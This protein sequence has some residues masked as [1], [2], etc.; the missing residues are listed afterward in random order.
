MKLMELAGHVPGETRLV[1]ADVEISSVEIDSRQVGAGALF[2]CIPG[3]QMDGHDFAPGAVERGAAALVVE[4]VLP[5]NVPQLLVESAREAL[6][7]IAAAFYGN[8]ACGMRLIGITGTKG[9]TTVSYLVKSILD[10]AGIKTGLIGTVSTYIGD[11]QFPS[12]LSTPDPIEFHSILRRMADAN[13]KIVVMEVTAHALAQHRVDGLTYEV[14]AFTNFSQDHLDYFGTMERYLDAKLLLARQAKKMI[15][16]VDDDHLSQA[17][18]SGRFACPVKTV[19]I[20]ERADI[21][22]KN[23]E[24]DERGCNFLLC[25]HKRFRIPVQLRVPGIFNVYNS[26]VAAALCNAVG[27]DQDAIRRGLE[28]TRAIPGRIELLNTGTPYHVILDYA[29]SPD[30]L[31]NVLK[32]VRQT[33]RARVIALFGCGGDRDREKRPMMGEIGGRLADFVILT[34]DNPRSEDPYEILASVEEGIKRTD[35]PYVVIEN[36]REAIREALTIARENDVIVLAGKGHETYQ[37]ICGVKHPFDERIV[38]A[39]LLAQIRGE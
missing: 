36:R 11:E 9:K 14:A 39:E 28:A 22:A 13:V 30:A 37:E 4:R 15:V 29:H 38:V 25:F 16:N 21:Y 27:V 18:Q 17:L 31:E 3:S 2:F 1:G 24:I 6:A 20:R 32:A 23:I 5:L 34:S 35:C 8:P 7:Y 10:A 33:A 19:G 26:L 12:R